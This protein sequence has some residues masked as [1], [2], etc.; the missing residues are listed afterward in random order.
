MLYFVPTPIG[1]LEDITVR[2]KR[3]LSESKIVI[4]E[5]PSKTMQLFNLL[6]IAKPEK[7]IKLSKNQEINWNYKKILPLL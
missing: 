5:D 7:F 6:D 1:N 3:I 2:A 4:A